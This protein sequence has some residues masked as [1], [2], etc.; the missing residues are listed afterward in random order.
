M[1]WRASPIASITFA[2]AARPA[3]A[4]PIS[5][6]KSLVGQINYLYLLSA[7]ALVSTDTQSIVLLRIDL[8]AANIAAGG[9]RP[10]SHLCSTVSCPRWHHTLLCAVESRTK[11][12]L[13]TLG[14]GTIQSIHFEKPDQSAYFLQRGESSE[15]AFRYSQCR[16]RYRNLC[17]G[18][19][20]STGSNASVAQG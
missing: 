8:N 16:N 6:G 12:T 7:T 5:T 14:V 4:R 15:T 13:W 3:S 20:S 11:G 17:V 18:Y 9:C 10:C 1:G 19:S 2:L